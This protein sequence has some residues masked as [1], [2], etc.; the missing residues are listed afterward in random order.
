MHLR[1]VTLYPGK[2][3]TKEHYPFNLDIFQ[4]T[5]S[6]PFVT[7]ITFFIG[8]NGTGKS[9]LLRALCNKCGIF[10]WEDTQHS[11]LHFNPYEEQLYQCI[12]VEWTDR[13]VP[14]SFFSSQIFQDYARFL[15]EVAR[16]DPGILQYFGGSSLVTQ[17]HG[18]SLISFF[19]ARYKI[20]GI[21]F[22]DEPETALSPQ[23][24]LKLLGILSHMSKA[25]HAQFIVATHSPILLAC[26][27]A[28]I[29]SFDTAPIK[30]IAYEETQYY[31]TY[32]D[33]INNREKYLREL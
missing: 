8:E 1:K 26:P 9:T 30:P 19:Q 17:S 24:Q 20:K 18:E 32:K 3:P 33:F 2:Y 31:R 28:V 29:Y 14:G 5:D 11:R 23:N 21:Y 4:K 25:G 27:G 7:P 10:I 22:L 16:A 6:I 15:D 12:E 13:S